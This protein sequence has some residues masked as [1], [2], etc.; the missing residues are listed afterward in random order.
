MWVICKQTNKIQANKLC[1]R[2]RVYIYNTETN[3]QAQKQISA[4]CCQ[5]WLPGTSGHELVRLTLRALKT[6]E[7]EREKDV[8]HKLPVSTINTAFETTSKT[9]TIVCI[10]SFRAALYMVKL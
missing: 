5:A 8:K 10:Q 6:N 9:N 2:V 7:R 4:D 1:H 3:K